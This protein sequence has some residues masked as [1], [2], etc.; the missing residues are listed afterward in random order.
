[1]KYLIMDANNIASL[2]FFRAKSTMMKD[3]DNK[4]KDEKNTETH[5]D[6]MKGVKEGI[7]GFGMH[8]FFNKVH[9]IIKLNKDYR[10]IFIW[11]G[12]YGSKW[13][14]EVKSE[15]KANRKHDGDSFYMTFIN[16][17]NVCQG[18]LDNYPVVQYSK[19]DAEAD[20][21]IYSTCKLLPDAEDIKVV[22][23]D[24]DMIQLCQQFNNVR[25]WSPIKKTYHEVPE[26]NY[27]LCKAVTGDKSDNI[28]GVPKYGPKKGAKVAIAGLITL[29]EEW[30]KLVEQNLKIIDMSMNPHEEDNT[31]FVKSYLDCTSEDEQLHYTLEAIR[32]LFFEF[33]LKNQV[34]KFGS[35]SKLI[36][37]LP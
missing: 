30:H 4:F 34:E 2:S 23:T 1:M 33:K 29:P 25:I 28:S 6:L 7:T 37:S 22:S 10:V 13:R 21:L 24:T 5:E 26:Y 20:D 32:D 14:K 27:A 19:E 18:I 35:T 3:I 17:M 36:K 16:M 12:R 9:S 31:A 15:Y 11:D 8:M